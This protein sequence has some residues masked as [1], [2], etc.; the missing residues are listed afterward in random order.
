MNKVEQ[1]REVLKRMHKSPAKH[2]GAYWR[3][4]CQDGCDACAAIRILEEL[5]PVVLNPCARKDCKEAENHPVHQT[6]VIAKNYPQLLDRY[7]DYEPPSK[8]AAA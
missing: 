7:H 3:G 2:T 6:A 1:L 4:E 5:H 8:G